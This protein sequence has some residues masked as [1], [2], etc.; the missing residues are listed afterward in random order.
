M[1]FKTWLSTITPVDS[2]AFDLFLI[3]GHPNIDSTRNYFLHMKAKL[4]LLG[5]KQTDSNPCLFISPTVICLIYVDNA[6]LVYRDQNSVDD[7]TNRMKHAEMLFNVE[8]DVAGYLGV[9]IDQ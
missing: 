3:W 6:L 7:L 4:E 1:H 2:T 8:S 5:F 9:L